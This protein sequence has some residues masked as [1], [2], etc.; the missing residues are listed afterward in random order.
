M[1]S[2]LRECLSDHVREV[3][4]DGEMMVWHRETQAYA[5]F[6]YN[7]SLGDYTRRLSEEVQPCYVVF[8]LLWLNG[9][10]L[11]SR[12]MRERRAALLEYARLSEHSS[13]RP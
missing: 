10:N 4:L 12:P 7:R 9:N 2:V 8:D 13:R 1:W 5:P 6:G 3:I 11:A